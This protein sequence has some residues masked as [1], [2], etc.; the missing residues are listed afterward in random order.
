MGYSSRRISPCL[1]VSQAWH[2]VQASRSAVSSVVKQFE[3]RFVDANSILQ[4][5]ERAPARFV[6]WGFSNRPVKQA[7]HPKSVEANKASAESN[8]HSI[9][10]DL[11]SRDH[12]PPFKHSLTT[13]AGDKRQR[14]KRVTR[15]YGHSYLN[16]PNDPFSPLPFP[17]RPL[18]L[19]VT[20]A[21]FYQTTSK[22]PFH[23]APYQVSPL[24]ISFSTGPRC[25]CLH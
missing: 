23:G 13:G 19:C 24:L 9:R 14:G 8:D 15:V 12:P 21:T 25:S 18:C 10:I 6:Y 11:E 3:S 16:D 20:T 4:T 22:Q 1:R 5:R 17:F 7:K 2:C